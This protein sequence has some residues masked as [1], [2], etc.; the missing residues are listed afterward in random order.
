M[1]V[2][3]CAD[4]QSMDVLL[5]VTSVP[6]QSRIELRI[7]KYFQWYVATVTLYE[8]KTLSAR[9]MCYFWKKERLRPIC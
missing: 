2:D 1:A 4:I 8:V 6:L 7:A 9:S 5:S 3:Y